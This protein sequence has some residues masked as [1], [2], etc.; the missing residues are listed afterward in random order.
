MRTFIV[1]LAGMALAA[2]LASCGKQADLDRPTLGPKARADYSAQKRGPGGPRVDNETA[3][4]A[5]A[6]PQ[7][8]ALEPYENPAPASQVPIPGERIYPSGSPATGG[9]WT[10][11]D[12]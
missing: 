6:E 11:P 10:T 5:V 12:P 9:P 3:A 2:A 4:N 1:V 8:P 7:N